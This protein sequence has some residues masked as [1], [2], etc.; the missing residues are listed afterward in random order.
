[1]PEFFPYL[2]FDA[3]ALHRITRLLDR[4]SQAQA[5]IRKMIDIPKTH[6]ILIRDPAR[7]REYTGVIILV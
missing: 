1:M 5:G 3:I 7:L 4:D 2:T 6:E